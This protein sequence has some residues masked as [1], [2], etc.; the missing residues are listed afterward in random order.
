MKSWC[1]LTVAVCGI[2]AALCC[3]GCGRQALKPEPIPQPGLDHESLVDSLDLPHPQG[4]H[5]EV[6]P[7]PG[8]LNSRFV[9]IFFDFDRFNIRDDQIQGVLGNARLLKENAAVR[10]IVQGH[11]DERGTEEYNLGLGERRACAV[12]D[13]LAALG[14]DRK[15]M[16]IVSYGESRPFAAGHDEGAWSQNRRA[17]FVVVTGSAGAD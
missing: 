8:A 3:A 16:G 13:Y 1:S 10:L 17:Q 6:A 15:R 14:I 11:C 12:R 2:L 7:E 9:P 5:D 4:L